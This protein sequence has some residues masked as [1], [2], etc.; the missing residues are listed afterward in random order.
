MNNKKILIIAAHPDDE[1]LGCGG[2]TAKFVEEG[3]KVYTLI[4]GEGITSRDETRNRHKR[5]KEIKELRLQI[6][7][8]S[9]IV[10]VRDAFVFDFPDNRFDTVAMLD[11][12]KTIEKVKIDVKPDIV[13]THHHG[14]L[15]IDHRITFE[16]VMTAFR[17]VKGE[18]VR[19]IYSFEVPSS[20]EWNASISTSYF[21][22]NYFVDISKT[23][24][25][26]I[27]AMKEYKSE[28]REYPHPRS[29]EAIKIYAK[30]WGIQAGLQAAEA[31]EV[32]RMIR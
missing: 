19:E 20:T 5:E 25:L 7:R 26:K 14:D 6:E 1:I 11:I 10:G 2:T 32:I 27:K 29:P 17:P 16:A 18:K 8:A 9:K 13:F 21:M 31:F 4:L 28:I 15:N 30:R 24:E 12:V 22:P 3:N 23:L